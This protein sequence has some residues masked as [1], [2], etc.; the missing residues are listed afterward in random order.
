MAT[1]IP[2]KKK[3]DSAPTHHLKLISEFYKTWG[4]RINAA[5][6]EAICVRN[7]SG[8]CHRTVD[9]QSK[10]LKLIL[11]G[12]EIT[13]KNNI[14]YLGIGFDKL[15]KFNNQAR[16]TLHTFSYTLYINH[17]PQNTKLL[18]YKVVI[19]SINHFVNTPCS[20]RRILLISSPSTKIRP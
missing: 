7:A 6:S 10:K 15:M 16:T 11:E 19:R 9:P 13:F 4:I 1:I 8:K 20:N 12:V 2:L 14:K 18:L 3:P 5:K 17:L